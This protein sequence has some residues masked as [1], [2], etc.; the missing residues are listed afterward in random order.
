VQAQE[1]KISSEEAYKEITKAEED[2]QE[3][4]AANFSITEVNDSIA[5]ATNL[6]NAYIALETKKGKGNVDFS[7]VISTLSKINK[8]KDNAFRAY[9]ELLILESRLKEFADQ[10]MSEATEIFNEA[11]REFRDG[12]YEKSSTLIEECYEKISELQAMA[13]K[14]KIIYEAG[15]R[16]I[17][18]FFKTRYREI[19]ITI[20]IF[21][22][23]FFTLKD[24]V[25]SY[26]VNQKIQKL[27]LEREILFDLIKKA[28]VLYFNKGLLSESSYRIKTKQFSELIRDLNR[29]LP[30]LK[31]KIE[32]I[33]EK[34]GIK[35]FMHSLGFFRTKEERLEI[36]RKKEEK[37][38]KET[39]E[40]QKNKLKLKEI[41]EKGKKLEK[42]KE[43][44]GKQ[45]RE[46]RAKK[47]EK[48]LQ[49]KLMKKLE[50]Q[51]R[52]K[53]QIGRKFLKKTK[54]KFK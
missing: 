33:K 31:I 46:R 41:L 38:E 43:K 8:I 26:F 32:K 16:T 36:K 5:G 3:M 49:E 53:S 18:H 37:R 13:T 20:T 21:L 50:K 23:L 29:R 19:I 9:D 24:K 6:Y 22:I 44:E 39:K 1:E 47:Y 40:E 34:K 25:Y 12:R 2:M 51:A 45:K 4:L 14:I 54:K 48:R 30:I 17:V 42:I 7:S 15:T 35:G 28:Q 27:E 52:K 10:N 11:K